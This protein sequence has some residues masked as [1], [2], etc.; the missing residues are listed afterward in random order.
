MTARLKRVTLWVRDASRSLSLYRDVLGLE[1]LE[2]K[3]LSG[4][5]I[6]QLVGLEH[7]TM[8]IV[9][10]GPSAAT[11]GWVGL[12]EIRDTSPHPMSGLAPVAGFPLYG[13]STLVF[14]VDDAAAYMPRLQT[15]AGVR[16][17]SGPSGYRKSE[18][19]AAMPAGRYS[20]LIFRDADG[21]LVSLLG[22]SPG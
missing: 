1:V 22:F 5:P 13:Q 14:D 15:L 17:L 9:H 2:D 4:P 7:A 8:R 19:S 6:A 18:S 21:F 12:Y 11:H 3:T 20:E 16:V 10:L